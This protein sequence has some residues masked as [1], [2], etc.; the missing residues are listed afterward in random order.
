[1]DDLGLHIALFLL[2]A[3]VIVAVTCMYTEAE[4]GKALRLFPRR[5]GTFVLVSGVIV[6]A[7]IVI[8]NT[9]A[10]VH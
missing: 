10:S 6:A 5:Y 3:G 8:Q 4:D 2:S 1:M 7:M 9:L